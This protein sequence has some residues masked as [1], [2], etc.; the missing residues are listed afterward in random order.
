MRQLLLFQLQLNIDRGF[1]LAKLF[2]LCLLFR[3]KDKALLIL[4]LGLLKV[5]QLLPCLLQAIL[6]LLD[7]ALVILLG[8]GL[9]LADAGERTAHRGP[10]AQ[11]DQI[12]VTAEMF[13]DVLCQV[14]I[15]I[16]RGCDYTEG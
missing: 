16:H 4:F 3:R 7:L 9:H 6:Q 11:A 14:Q 12:T 10:A 5:I 13:H 8:L 1:L 2:H 15:A